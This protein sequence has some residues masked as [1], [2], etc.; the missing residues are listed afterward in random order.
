M[1]Q[2]I[3]AETLLAAY[4]GGYFPMAESRNATALFWFNP[5]RRGI[6]PIEHFHVPRRLLQWMKKS[7]FTLTV[8]TAFDE[9]IRN[10]AQREST[11]INDDIIALYT[12]LFKRSFAHSVECWDG[13][14]LVGGIYGV[15]LGGAFF[16][17][18]M[19]SRQPNAS[20]VALVHLVSLLKKQ[21]YTLFD[22]QYV[23]EHLKQFGVIE[24]SREE[25]LEKLE[26]AV[27]CHPRSPLS[28]G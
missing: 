21:G 9:V 15:S 24:I 17:E 6:L 10:C 1:P 3:T 25:Y 4:A 19:F 16:G 8:D 12:T 27:S 28:R 22:T 11:W 14:N 18:S 23:N 20:K 7:P 26:R 5:Q 2:K 13:K